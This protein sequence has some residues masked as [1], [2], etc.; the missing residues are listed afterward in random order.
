MYQIFPL[1]GL[2]KRVKIVI[3]GMKTYH[4]ATL[5]AD[6]EFNRGRIAPVVDNV[7]KTTGVETFDVGGI[8]QTRR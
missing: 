3:F 1:Q 2:P 5:L 7:K 8:E 4:L 6:D